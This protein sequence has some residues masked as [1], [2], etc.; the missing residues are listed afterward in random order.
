MVVAGAVMAGGLVA[1]AAPAWADTGGVV[2]SE[3]HFHPGSDLDT[4]DFLELVNTSAQA[5]DVSGWSFSAG[6]TGSLPAGSVIPAGW[7]LRRLARR[8]TVHRAVRRRA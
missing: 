8:C 2:I 1:T 5:V 7:L 6:I 3:L 4:D